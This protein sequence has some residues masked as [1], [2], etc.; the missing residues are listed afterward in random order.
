MKYILLFSFLL[1]T[2][3]SWSDDKNTPKTFDYANNSIKFFC[4]DHEHP[5]I[6][7]SK[8]ISVIFT[9]T[10]TM[11]YTLQIMETEKPLEWQDE[12]SPPG[13]KR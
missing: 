1:F 12:P 2:W 8:F 10:T 13:E 6:C 3:L 11:E 7:K 4:E 9:I 5:E